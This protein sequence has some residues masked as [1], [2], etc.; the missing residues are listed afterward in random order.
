MMKNLLA[1]AVSGGLAA[2]AL[3]LWIQH[4]NRRHVGR[5]E[6]ERAGEIQRWEDEGG[7]AAPT[8]SSTKE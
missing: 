7:N 5:A 4:E 3:K 2:M 6:R 8:A 1:V